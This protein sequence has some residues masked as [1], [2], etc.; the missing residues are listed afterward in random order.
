MHPRIRTFAG[1]L[2]LVALAGFALRAGAD[3]ALTAARVTGGLNRPVFVT[4]PP[5]DPRLFIVELRGAD[6]KGRIRIFKYGP[7]GLLSRPFFVTPRGLATG[8][9]Q[10]L[11]GLAF[12]PDYATSGAFYIHYTDTTGVIKIERH[13]VSATNPDS[14]D[15]SGEVLLSIFHPYANHNGG[16]LGFGPDGYL[17][18]G[19][20][21]GGSGGDPANRAQNAD[22]LLGK[23]LRIDVS[24]TTGYTT[25]PDNPFAGAIPGRDEVYAIG[26]RNPY[27]NSFDRQTGDLILGDVGQMLWEEIDY[28]PAASGA[29]K[30]TNFGWPCWEAN[31]SYD[32]Q[33]PTPCTTCSNTTCMQ[34]PAY[35][36]DH[37]VGRC[38]V[39]GG[40]VYRGSAIPDLVG[41]YFFA[42]YCAGRTYSG[43]F[44]GG[45]LA[46]VTERTNELRPVDQTVNLGSIS[47]FGEDKDGELYICD[48]GGELFKIIPLA[49][50]DTT[51]V[52]PPVRPIL[53]LAGAM[54]FRGS[55]R[56]A[57][58]LPRATR[59]RLTVHDLLGRQVRSLA[60]EVFPAGARTLTWDGLDER[61]AVAPPGI[62]LVRIVTPETAEAVRAIRVR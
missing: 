43:Q 11:L 18:I 12:A 49:A 3:T 24:P 4:S 10:G 60:D 7:E 32:L 57:L 38:S 27:R 6:Q 62:Y 52:P 46:N 36:Y 14:A 13:H 34:F 41:T 20:G 55:L 1:S 28:A 22:S 54:P 45:D 8:L 17:Y 58:D 47:S 29:G 48:L 25:P 40:Y 31:H 30:G 42:D 35:E 23:I 53:S 44:V 15:S 26:L 61:G 16:W 50:L 21:D 19:L 2:A 33:R 5:G 9:E 51:P 37:S 39:T 59:V 56:L